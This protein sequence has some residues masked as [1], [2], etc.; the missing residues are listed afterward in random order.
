MQHL[1]TTEVGTIVFTA[2]LPDGAKSYIC[3]SLS[4]T[5]KL[6]A[7]PTASVVIGCGESIRNGAYDSADNNAEDLLGI[8]SKT[9][10]KSTDFLN[11]SIYEQLEDAYRCIFKGCIVSASLV[12]KTGGV[13]MRAVRVECMNAACK[14]YCQPFSAYTNRCA[15]DIVNKILGED[16]KAGEDNGDNAPAA[17]GLY[18]IATMTGEELADEMNEYIQNMDIATKI[19][20]IADGIS[21]LTTKAIEGGGD[22]LE[23]A[24]LG[25]IL[26]VG[27]YI[28]SDYFLDYKNLDLA[29]DQT[30]EQF[31]LSLCTALLAGL[32]N[33]SILD[34]IIHTI[35]STNYMMNLVPTWSDKDFVLE[36]RPSRAWNTQVPFNLYF[37]DLAEMNSVFNPLVHINDPEVFV[38]DFTPALEFGEAEGTSG[39]P[40]S[41]LVGAFSTVPQV[42]E[43]IKLRFSSSSVEFP[44]RKK[45]QENLLHYKW[46]TYIAPDWLMTSLIVQEKGNKEDKLR[47]AIENQRQ[48]DKEQDPDNKDKPLIKDYGKAEQI[49]DQ[50]AKALY[51]HLHGDSATANLTLLPDMRFGH[52][53]GFALEEHIGEIVDIIPEE[54]SPNSNLAMRGMLEGIQFE[55]SAGL[56]ASCRYSVLLSR[57]RP[58][59]EDEPVIECPL[60]VTALA[61]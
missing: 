58:L 17:F 52:L 10:G 42:A 34:T 1:Y 16:V 9:A 32:K 31:N 23:D 27:D 5:M 29:N 26:H 51:A 48:W 20:Y 21:V 3:S 46:R 50:V 22:P 7:V 36:L 56:S 12:Y 15:S 18:D 44:L 25:S 45:L 6:N 57:V 40:G 53:D 49:A 33:G 4:L 14:L 55:Y 2:E 39:D 8:I 41:S 38:A 47:E 28:K 59:V 54:K 60:Y 43:W 30:D 19:A 37:A 24:D 11:C 13:T 35:T 61:K